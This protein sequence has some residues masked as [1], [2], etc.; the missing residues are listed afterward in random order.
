MK[1]VRNILIGA[2]GLAAAGGFAAPAAAQYYPPYGGYG[3]GNGNVIVGAILD[4]ILR[5]GYNNGYGNGY[6]GYGNYGGYGSQGYGY[7]NERVAI[8]QCARAAEARLNR[9]RS[10]GYYGG[11]NTAGYRTAQ[12]ERVERRNNGFKVWG[13]AT[14]GNY[15]GNY[16]AYGNGYG[17]YGGGYNNYGYANAPDYRFDCNVDYRGRVRDVDVNRLNN[18]YGYRY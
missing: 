9:N 5:G 7:Q 1:A 10:G 14:S 6:G 16:G 8:D 15:R 13:V 17:G 2:A 18:R 3:G 4:S 12:I 11:Y